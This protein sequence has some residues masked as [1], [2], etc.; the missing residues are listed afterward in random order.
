MHSAPTLVGPEA[1]AAGSPM[2]SCG[3]SHSCGA[4]RNRYI[5]SSPAYAQSRVNVTMDRAIATPLFSVIT[6]QPLYFH[7]IAHSFPQRRSAVRR[8]FDNLRTLSVVLGGGTPLSCGNRDH[9]FLQRLCFHTLTNCSSRNSVAFTT[10]LIARGWTPTL[11]IRTLTA[12]NVQFV[13]SATWTRR[14]HPTIIA[15]RSRFQVHG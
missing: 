9:S 6:M 3:P 15:A 4:G 8:A 14:A 10:I 11:G 1:S 13:R 5:A 2:P 7:A 12:S